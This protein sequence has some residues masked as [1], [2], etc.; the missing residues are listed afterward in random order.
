[1]ISSNNCMT[2]MWMN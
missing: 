1:V 2:S